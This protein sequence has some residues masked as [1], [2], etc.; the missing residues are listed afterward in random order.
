M[1]I[2]IILLRRRQRRIIQV[3]QPSWYDPIVRS[4]NLG[5]IFTS[6]RECIDQL[7]MD[8]GCFRVLCSLVREF[9]GLRDTRNMKVEEMVAMFLHILGH[10]KK[11]RAIH[12]EFQRSIETIS[13]NFHKVL[14]SV[15]KLWSVLLKKPQ[16]IPANHVDERWKW[17]KNC[18]GAL[19]GTYIQVHVPAVDK[20]RYRSRKNNV[21]TNVLGVCALDMQFIYTLPGWEGSAADGKVLRDALSRQNGV[22]VPRGCYYLVDAGYKNCEGFLAPY[23]GQRYHL[24]DWKNSPIKKEEL[25][26]MKHASA[27]NVIERTVGLLKIRWAI[28][29]NPS[30]YPIDTQVDIILAC[31]Y[32]HSLIRQQ[33][34]SSDPFVQELDAFMQQ[35]EVN[36]DTIQSTETSS[37]W[38]DWRDKLADE[39]WNA[40][41]A[42]R[43]SR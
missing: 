27:R 3:R 2:W 37:Q 13:R 20:P 32:L 28:I 29:R 43:Q 5:T 42:R 10:D 38:N 30:Y 26:N 40:W 24:Q 12:K 15:L 35:Q 16:P 4:Q 21:A 33:M 6:D 14:K 11:D 41:N 31:C 8:R 9:G 7:R 18:V 25:F 1:H 23:R 34:G 17:F 39:M 19:D 22:V 36:G